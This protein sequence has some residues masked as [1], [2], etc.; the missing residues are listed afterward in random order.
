MRLLYLLQHLFVKTFVIFTFYFFLWV[1]LGTFF[2]VKQFKNSLNNFLCLKIT[3][4]VIHHLYE[5]WYNIYLENSSSFFVKTVNYNN[6]WS[7]KT[8]RSCL[9]DCLFFFLVQNSSINN[10]K[11]IFLL[12]STFGHFNSCYYLFFLLFFFYKPLLS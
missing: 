7:R 8:N 3:I 2:F 10:M 1:W 12:D 11:R 4:K 9:F 6:I 5:V